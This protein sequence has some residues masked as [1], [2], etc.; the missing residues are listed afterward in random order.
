MA[1]K[2]KREDATSM[3][4]KQREIAVSEFFAKNRHLLGFDNP[5]KALLT[6]V[7]EAVD[8]ALDAC[9]EAEI[10]PSVEV[11]IEEVKE[12]R[13]VL[14]ITDNGPGILKST[15]GKVFGQL[16]YGSKFHRLKQSRG[17]QGIGISAAVMYGQMTTGQPSKVTSKCGK[18]KDAYWMDIQIDTLKNRSKIVSEGVDETD[19]WMRDSG[20]S[21]AI[22]LEGSYKGGKHSVDSYL[23]QT[24]LAN[25]HCN[26]RFVDPK[27]RIY[28]YP[29]VV[30]ELPVEAKEIKP[31]PHGIELGTL[32]RMLQDA[33]GES[34]AGFLHENFCRVST[35]VAGQ[36]CEIAGV[37]SKMPAT[38]AGQTEVEGL[39]KSIQDTK[40]MAPPT[41]CLSPIGEEAIAKGLY[42]LFVEAQR[43]KATAKKLRAEAEL[44]GVTLTEKA[45]LL[46]RAEEESATPEGETAEAALAD[47]AANGAAAGPVVKEEEERPMTPAEM[48]AKIELGEEGAMFSEEEGY[49]VTA[50]TRPPAVYRGNPFQVEVGLFWG[51]GLPADELASVY[52]FANR[53]PLQ[54]Q[55]SAC[56][57]SKAVVSAPWRS[58]QVQQSKGAFPTGPLVLMVHIASGWVPYTS[59]S[60]EAI[61]PYDEILQELR[62]AVMEC[63][64]RL[65]RFLKRKKRELDEEKKRSYIIKYM[66]PIGDALQEI[67]GFSDDAKAATMADLKVILEE[68]RENKPTAKARIKKKA[69]AKK[70]EDEKA[71]AAERAEEHAATTT[72]NNPAEE[73]A[74]GK[75]KAKKEAQLTL[76]LDAPDENKSSTKSPKGSAA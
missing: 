73:A 48:I 58:Y 4:A 34:V 76:G 3:A 59:E 11:R 63:G 23:R 38:K 70:K 36:I 16:L 66:D 28:E 42:W 41:N 17:Q 7:R 1:V 2:K 22:V 44:D 64:R 57:M 26:L 24:A 8:N 54:Y 5:T 74:K 61:A 55:A 51:K 60:K 40:L 20:T 18:G 6:T 30:E 49:F 50:C 56:A 14:T 21:I 12:G 75:S 9:E 33:R 19:F 72:V 31:H 62:K 27:G 39:Y 29:R 32:M 67:L 47:A 25:P 68:S 69:A 37:S 45:E 71:D 53:V 35:K 10:L 15:A 13:Y 65:Q 52:R 43:E 46:K